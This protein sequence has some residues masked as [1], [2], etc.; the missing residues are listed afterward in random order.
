VKVA[1]DRRARERV[2]REWTTLRTLHAS[3]SLGPWRKLLPAPVVAGESGDSAFTAVAPSVGVD[4]RRFAHRDERIVGTAASAL[5]PLRAGAVPSRV[6]DDELERWVARPAA[7]VAGVPAVA[8]VPQLADAVRRME[9]ELRHALDGRVLPVGLAHGD[10]WLGN[11]L[12]TDDGLTPTAI[13]DWETASDGELPLLDLVHLLVTSCALRRRCQLG[14]VVR[15]TRDPDVAVL[16]AAVG[17]GAI[18]PGV[19]V[20]LAWLRHVANNLAKSTTYTTHRFWLR[21][22]V[23]AVLESVQ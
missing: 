5:A 19:L 21:S 18:A 14:T 11:L 16:V 17:G 2:R 13:L 23:V 1:V 15:A 6:G 22:N 10:W 7:I 4:G 3:A 9:A 20:R 12:T 8:R